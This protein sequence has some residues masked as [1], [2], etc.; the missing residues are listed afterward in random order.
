MARDDMPPELAPLPPER[1]ANLSTA[2]ILMLVNGCIH[3]LGSIGA[4]I[5]I[6]VLGVVI[7]IF[8]FGVGFLLMLC[9]LVFPLAYVAWGIFEIVMAARIMKGDGLMSSPFWIGIVDIVLGAMAL[10][11]VHGIIILMIG[12]INTILLSDNK[13]KDYFSRAH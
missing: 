2:A 6:F 4:V 12:I 10:T 8:T 9:C 13:V 1:P 3:I 11:T 5:V 7:G